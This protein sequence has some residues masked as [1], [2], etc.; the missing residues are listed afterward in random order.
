MPSLPAGTRRRARITRGCANRVRKSVGVIRGT[1][2]FRSVTGARLVT[3]APE[4]DRAEPAQRELRSAED[5]KNDRIPAP[6]DRANRD[7]SGTGR[8]CPGQPP[9]HRKGRVLF[10][11]SREPRFAGDVDRTDDEPGNSGRQVPVRDKQAAHQPDEQDE[12]F[13]DRSRCGCSSSQLTR[14]STISARQL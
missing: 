1:P 7:E 12:C 2:S 4:H 8:D 14:L 6:V 11:P 5:E 10:A 3:L 9:R 13:L